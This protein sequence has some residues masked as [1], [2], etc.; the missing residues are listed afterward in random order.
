M[1]EYTLLAQRRSIFGKKLKRERRRGKLPAVLYGH[2]IASEPLFIDERA[3]LRILQ[4][5]GS[6]AIIKLEL[7]DEAGKEKDLRNVLIHEVAYDPLERKLLHADLYQVRMDEKVRTAVPLVFVGES[8]AVKA[9]GGVLIKTRQSLEVEALPG[10]LPSEITVDI[11]GLATFEDAIHVKDLKLPKAV[12]IAID[13][14]TPIASVAPPRTEEELKALEEVVVE[15]VEEVKVET[16]EK[17]LE[18]EVAKKAEEAAPET[19]SA[20]K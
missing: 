20:A 13:A 9:L 8:P 2:G 18:R 16:E 11:S 6:N 14:E 10:D 7:E 15:K 4:S 5:A 12:T 1:P 17:K 19:P 3:F